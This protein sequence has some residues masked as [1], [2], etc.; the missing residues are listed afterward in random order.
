M[1]LVA[2]PAAIAVIASAL[3]LVER[4]TKLQEVR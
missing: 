3:L 2:I 1:L 4:R